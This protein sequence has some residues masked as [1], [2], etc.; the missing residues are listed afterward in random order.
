ML[1]LRFAAVTLRRLANVIRH[2]Y[3]RSRR[4]LIEQVSLYFYA[5]TPCS[6]KTEAL[7]CTSFDGHRLLPLWLGPSS[8]TYLSMLKL[9]S[10]TVCLLLTGFLVSFHHYSYFPI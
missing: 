2:A 7:L 5:R 4:P 9:S 1:Q 3:Q 10:C 8:I 6:S